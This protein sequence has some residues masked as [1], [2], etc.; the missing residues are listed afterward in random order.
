MNKL[1]RIIVALAATATVSTV[2][3]SAS[4]NSNPTYDFNI[5]YNNGCWSKGATK[6][7]N[8]NM[9]DVQT[10]GGTV[11][12]QMPMYVTTY[13]YPNTSNRY[14]KTNTDMLKSNDDSCILYYE[15]SYQKGDTYYLRGES[16]YYSMTAK[17]Y[18]NP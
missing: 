16:G 14:R 18:W 13:S 4:A 15:G 11:C 5:G 2:G 9:V 10:T 6:E 1:K 3:I 8:Y 7:D 12:G 17:G